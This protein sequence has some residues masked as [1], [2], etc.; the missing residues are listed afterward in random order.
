MNQNQNIE[1]TTVIFLRTG[2]KFLRQ[3]QDL[4]DIT[5]IPLLN[6]Y[7]IKGVCS[8]MDQSK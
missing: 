1:N 3:G 5:I 7:K 4:N 2:S 8:R 6:A